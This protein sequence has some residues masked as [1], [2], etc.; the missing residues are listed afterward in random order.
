MAEYS[1]AHSPHCLRSSQ[2]GRFVMFLQHLAFS[3]DVCHCLV[4]RSIVDAVKWKSHLISLWDKFWCQLQRHWPGQAHVI[5]SVIKS[6]GQLW[7]H[8]LSRP[9]VW[10]IFNQWRL[11]VWDKSS[12]PTLG[13]RLPLITDICSVLNPVPDW[14]SWFMLLHSS[15]IPSNSWS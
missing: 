4:T 1:S 8:H 3:A 9:R 15:F 13:P 6:S 2:M 12:R 5:T 10:T 11:N 7:Q 14:A